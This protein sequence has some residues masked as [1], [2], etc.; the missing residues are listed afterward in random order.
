VVHVGTSSECFSSTVPAI[1]DMK[2]PIRI[3][4]S[5][6]RTGYTNQLVT[7][8]PVTVPEDPAG[9]LL[10]VEPRRHSA[11]DRAVSDSPMSRPPNQGFTG[12]SY[13]EFP[14]ERCSNQRK[15]S[16]SG[17]LPS[18]PAVAVTADHGPSGTTRPG[19]S[20]SPPPGEGETA[21]RSW[22][23]RRRYDPGDTTEWD[24]FDFHLPANRK[25]LRRVEDGHAPEK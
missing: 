7:Q 9:E 16:S 23:G 8:A 2:R 1:T 18:R 12:P 22:S 19:Y 13:T 4:G 3:T 11:A 15:S 14:A 24:G 21:R 5:A 20:V 10:C 25:R 17:K 6:R